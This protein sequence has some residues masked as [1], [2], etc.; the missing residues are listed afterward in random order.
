MGFPT[1]IVKP[2]LRI[3]I[4]SKY[5]KYVGGGLQKYKGKKF[6]VEERDVKLPNGKTMTFSI[7]KHPGAVT[8]LPF[9]GEK[10]VLLRQYRAPIGKWI[11]ELPAGTREKG[12]PAIETA[13]RELEEETGYIAGRITPMFR[14]FMSPGYTTELMHYF[15]AEDLKKSKPKLEDGE[16]ITNK[17]YSLEEA[18]KMVKK[19]DIMGAKD[20]AAI[21]Y[22][23]KN[24]KGENV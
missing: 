18:L 24:I 11:Y 12:E 3:W 23:V 22:Y 7:V 15:L 21:L 5:H 1:H 4:G 19:G 16:V 9:L 8:I 13:K 10:I 2:L 6:S 14:T 17:L 20:V